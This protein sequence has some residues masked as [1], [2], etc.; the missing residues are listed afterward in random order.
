MLRIIRVLILVMEII[1][2]LSDP[3]VVSKNKQCTYIS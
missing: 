3:V 1:L 2:E